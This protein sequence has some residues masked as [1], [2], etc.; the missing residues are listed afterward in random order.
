MVNHEL[1]Y[2]QV[3]DFKATLI[4]LPSSTLKEQT[5]EER[6]HWVIFHICLSFFKVGGSRI[7][8]SC[9]LIPLQGA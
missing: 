2:S 9:V 8:T 4:S 6:D 7:N 1:H 3:K 5:L